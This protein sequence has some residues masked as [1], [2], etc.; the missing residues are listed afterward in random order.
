MVD[1]SIDHIY[2][3]VVLDC[4]HELRGLHELLFNLPK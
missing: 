1:Q 3:S 4:L 2:V